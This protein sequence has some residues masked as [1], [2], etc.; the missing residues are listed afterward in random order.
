MSTEKHE[1]L[2]HFKRSLTEDPNQ[3]DALEGSAR[4]FEAAGQTARAA[5][6]WDKIIELLRGSARANALVS[7][8][9]LADDNFVC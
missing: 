3:I 1:A 8:A 7:R 6:S 9:R 2:A 5:D 4:V